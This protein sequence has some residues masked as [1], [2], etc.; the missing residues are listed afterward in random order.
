MTKNDDVIKMSDKSKKYWA[1]RITNLSKEKAR[2]LNRWVN[3]QIDKTI[4]KELSSFTKT[5]KLD[6]LTKKLTLNMKSL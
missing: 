2:E 3:D 5:C 4:N 6:K 1:D